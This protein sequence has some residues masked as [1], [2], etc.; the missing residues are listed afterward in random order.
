MSAVSTE[1]IYHTELIDGRKIQKPLPKNLHAFTQ[2]YLIGLFL[3]TLP[4]E[5]RGY[6]RI[7]RALRL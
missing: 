1:P 5:Y 3:K 6:V 4:H 2:T 7:E